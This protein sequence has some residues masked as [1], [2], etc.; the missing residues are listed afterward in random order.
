MSI[1]LGIILILVCAA[2]AFFVLIQN[3][4]GGGLSGQFGG[5][6]QQ[7]MGVQQSTDTVEKGTWILATVMA[8]LCLLMVMF[9]T[10]GTG[11]DS[12]TDRSS[13]AL[14]GAV[15]PPPTA[16][17]APAT[18]APST[19]APASQPSSSPAAQPSA[20]PAPAPAAG[21]TAPTTPPPAQK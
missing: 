14:K 5:L 6:G 20:A 15:A 17:A 16:P 3:P 12:A 1:L 13:N 19:P 9:G 11:K 4:K 18:Q 2:L 21:T 10:Q 8:A 7:M